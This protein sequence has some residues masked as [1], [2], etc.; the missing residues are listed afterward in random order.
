MRHPVDRLARSDADYVPQ[1]FRPHL[2]TPRRQ[3][4]DRRAHTARAASRCRSYPVWPPPLRIAVICRGRPTERPK[5]RP[6]QRTAAARSAPFRRNCAFEAPGSVA[7]RGRR[8]IERRSLKKMRGLESVPAWMLDAVAR[9]LHDM[10]EP[11]ELDPERYPPQ[12]GW[13]R[14]GV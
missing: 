12:A 11:T 6:C 2:Q 8:D 5:Q 9:C 10:Q 3:I 14:R 7:P 1:P 4:R 13:L